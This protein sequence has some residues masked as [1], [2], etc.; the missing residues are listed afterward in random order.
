VTGRDDLAA[1]ARLPNDPAFQELVRRTTPQV[2]EQEFRDTL[3]KVGAEID[4]ADAAGN[5][6]QGLW[7]RRHRVMLRATMRLPP[8]AE[9]LPIIVAL[10]RWLGVNAGLLGAERLDDLARR[11]APKRKAGDD[12]R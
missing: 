6:D 11:L 1:Y 2:V 9:G 7:L 3:A 5:R 4:E 12:A 8:S 10:D